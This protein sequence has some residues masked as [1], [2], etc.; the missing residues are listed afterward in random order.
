M[1]KRI[2][3]VDDSM[4]TRLILRDLLLSHG[5]SVVGEASNGRQA[6]EM[7]ETVRPDLV[8]VDARMPDMDGVTTIRHLRIQDPNAVT[9]LCAGSGER[10][11]VV[12]ALSA[13]ATDFCAKPY[14]PKRVVG[15]VRRVL[16]GMTQ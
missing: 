5:F 2:M 14:V 8:M 9:I 12:E 4:Y 10:S 7:Y 15:I 6:L 16:A 1:S 3:I 13:G 11:T